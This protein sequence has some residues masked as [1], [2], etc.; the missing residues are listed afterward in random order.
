M[1]KKILVTLDASPTDRAIIEHVKQL[2]KMMGSELVLLHVATG[3]VA[4]WHG[5]NAAGREVEEGEEY[6]KSVQREFEADGIPTQ[7]QL[8]CGNPVREIIRYVESTGCDLVAM[9]THGHRGVSD[10]IYGATADP[11]RHRVD[12]P[13]LLLKG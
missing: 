8:A 12:V 4:R 13:V 10:V 7:A 2:A 3:A 9:G 6:L 1:Y 5:A 11:V